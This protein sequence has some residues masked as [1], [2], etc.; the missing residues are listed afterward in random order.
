MIIMGIYKI[1]NKITK[2][3]YIGQ[4]VDIDKRWRREIADAFNSNSRAY[5]YPL[6]QAIRKY[7]IDNFDF[8]VLEECKREELNYKEKF[9]IQYYNSF[10]NGY[11]QTLGGD[12]NIQTPKEKIINVFYDLE[13]TNFTHSEIAKR[14][15]ISIEMVQGINTGRYWKCDNKS[16]PLQKRTKEELSSQNKQ[17]PICGKVINKESEH[18]IECAHKISRKVERPDKEQLELYLFS[19]KGNFSEA[20]RYYGVSDN[21]I[22]KWCKAYDLPTSSSAYKEL[23]EI[24]K[25]QIIQKRKVAQIDVKTDKILNIYDSISDACK[26]INKPAGDSHISAV[27]KGKRITAYGY[28]WKY[29]N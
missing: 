5:N 10:F 16:Y 9:W 8:L 3:C 28:K 24:K 29:I 20:S 18:C 23:K 22:R 17:C 6:S 11:N 15:N 2:K 13:N 21:A 12:T 14:Q 25:S 19:I 1:E 27:C 4:S 7:G 26:A